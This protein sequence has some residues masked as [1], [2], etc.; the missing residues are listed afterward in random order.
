MLPAVIVTTGDLDAV[1]GRIQASTAGVL[2][3]PIGQPY[4]VRGCAVRDPA[5][6]RP[7]FSQP[8]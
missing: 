8:R 1:T 5:G 2:Q 4:S 3:E 7:R 6:S